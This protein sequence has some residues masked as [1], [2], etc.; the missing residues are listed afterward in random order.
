[1]PKQAIP[2]Q[3]VDSAL[4]DK[5]LDAC[6]RGDLPELK[7]L[8]SDP[9]IKGTHSAPLIQLMLQ[10]SAEKGHV[11]LVAFL[12][13]SNPT[14]EIDTYLARSAAWGGIEVYKFLFSRNS[15][16]INWYFGHLG[17]AVIA[18]VKRQDAELLRFLLDNGGDPGRSIAESTRYLTFT[19]VETAVLQSTEEMVRILVS[20][21]ALLVGTEALQHAAALGRL[22][23]VRCLL[24][25]G[26]DINGILDPNS[27][28]GHPC[29]TYKPALH[30]AV[31]SGHTDTVRYLLEQGADPDLRDTAGQTA[32]RKAQ[33]SNHRE[34]VHMLE[35]FGKVA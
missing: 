14:I 34:I 27:P 28:Y 1:M 13:D 33:E 25:Q 11:S 7:S 15:D 26:A 32:L 9:D 16:I 35:Q 17:N 3:E 22:G 5:L 19:A 29:S 21:G 8:L 24:E 12:L 4:K 2:S 10:T 18:A 30:H 31:I 20:Y 23:M 6:S